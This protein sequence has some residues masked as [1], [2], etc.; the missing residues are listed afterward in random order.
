MPLIRQVFTS[1]IPVTITLAGLGNESVT[2]STVNDNSGFQFLA[3]DLQVK[4]RTGA[5]PLGGNLNIYILK[6][7]DDGEEY[8]KANPATADLLKSIPVTNDGNTE[9]IASVLI[10]TLPKY[11]KI[12]VQNLTGDVLDSGTARVIYEGKRV[13]VI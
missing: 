11:W 12:M 7:V 13:E 3:A 5:E 8:D 4:F 2:V 10:E 1:N 9:Y 6:S